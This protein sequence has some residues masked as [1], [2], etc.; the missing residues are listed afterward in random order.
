VSGSLLASH[1]YAGGG[2][3]EVRTTSLA[4][5]LTAAGR[6]ECDVLKLDVE[7]AEYEV[8]EALCAN[9]EVR[10]ARQVI[11]EFHHGWTEHPLEHTR[12]ITAKIEAAGFRLAHTENRNYLFIRRDVEH[13]R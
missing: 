1:T 9:R 4:E 8:L 12:E 11:A 3:L 10:R 2:Q 13:A 5:L 6:E 7:G